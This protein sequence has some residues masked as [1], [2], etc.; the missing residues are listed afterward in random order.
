MCQDVSSR[1]FIFYITVNKDR[2]VQ[3]GIHFE[4]GSLLKLESPII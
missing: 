1:Y 3:V 2:S 4:H